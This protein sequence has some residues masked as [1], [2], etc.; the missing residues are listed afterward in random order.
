MSRGTG[1]TYLFGTL[2]HQNLSTH[3]QQIKQQTI[4]STS[5]DAVL[6]ASFSTI[7]HIVN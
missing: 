3:K 6:H 7:K 1:L 4:S 2:Q 5:A